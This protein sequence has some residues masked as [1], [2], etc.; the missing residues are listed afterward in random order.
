ME[1]ALTAADLRGFR[2]LPVIH[3]GAGLLVLLIPVALLLYKPRGLTP[4]GWRK[5]YEQRS[6]SQP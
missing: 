1:T 3:A 5:Q 4:Y 6:V 2:I